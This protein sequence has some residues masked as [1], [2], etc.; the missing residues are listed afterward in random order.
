MTT[1]PGSTPPTDVGGTPVPPPD[2]REN[3]VEDDEMM[4]GGDVGQLRGGQ[5][6]GRG[7]GR[8]DGDDDEDE[9]AR[10]NVGG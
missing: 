2:D 3:P 7:H 1:S 9:S 5:G 8:D 4:Q 10:R 6:R